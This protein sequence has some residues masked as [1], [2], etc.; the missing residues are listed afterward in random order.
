MLGV[1]AGASCQ[2]ASAAQIS[3]SGTVVDPAAEAL[4][5]WVYQGTY[6]PAASGLAAAITNATLTLTRSGGLLY[7]FTSP[8]VGAPS[9]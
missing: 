4:T 9:N 5:T 6:T 7:T 3:F 1:L 2:L 8:L